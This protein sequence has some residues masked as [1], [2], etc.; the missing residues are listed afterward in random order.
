MRFWISIAALA[1]ASAACVG[2]P[3]A[4]VVEL[5]AR[6]DEARLR[7]DVQELCAAG[8][9]PADDPEAV[10]RTLDW[11]HARLALLGL[12][13][14]EERGTREMLVTRVLQDQGGSTHSVLA[15]E[16]REVVNLVVELPG[17]SRPWQVVELGAHYDTVPGSPGADDNASGVAA[18]LEAA[19]VLA[20]R[21][22]ARS[23]RVVFFGAEECG[24]IG[25]AMHAERQAERAGE[26]H[27]GAIVLDMVGFALREPD[28]QRM[29]LRVPLLFDPPTTADFVFVVGNYHSGGIGNLFEDA[30]D[31]YVPEL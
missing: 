3:N 23:V 6:V 9:R 27:V 18:L 31:R 7:A 1:L 11:L 21:P 5:V 13:G 25:S 8:P 28:T 14:H 26:W 19:R 2:P 29:P 17:A 15:R 10:R 4:E 12:V 22:R 30:A 16:L 24:L 20:E